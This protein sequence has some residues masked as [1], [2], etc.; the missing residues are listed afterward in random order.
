MLVAILC[1]GFTSAWADSYTITF[2]NNVN[3]ATGLSSSTNAST[4]ISSG[5][6]SYVTSKPFTIGSG[7]VY[8][9]DT[10]TCIRIG[11]SGNS[12]R[13][14]IGL[15]DTGKVKAT[16]IVVNC[17]YMSGSKN[18]DAKLNVNSIGEQTTPASADNKT[19][20]FASATD[21]ENIVLEGTAAIYIYSIT[22]N[23]STGGGSTGEETTTTI[24][25][26]GITN[27]NKFVSTV[28]G[29][30]SASV[31]YGEPAA[32]VS[33]ASVTW[34]GDNDAVATINS[35]TGVVTLVGA[36]TVTFTAEY[37][38]VTDTYLSS[39]D[40]YEMT[41]TNEDPSLETIWSED[42]SDYAANAVPSDGSFNYACTNGGGT[43]KIYT[44]ANA[45][46]TSPE[47]LVGKTNGT[48]SATVT[49]LHPTYSYS[50]D[51]T[52]RFKSNA[53]GINVNTT[54]DGITV[55]DEENEGEGVT[56]NTKETH[57]VTF[58]G[59]T[60]ETEN[61][62][63]VFTATTG[64][65]VRLD[66][67]VLKG[68]KA[69]LPITSIAF[70]E[71]K[72]A[73]VVVGY[74]VTLTPT[75]LP[76]NHTE[77]VDWESDATGVA[78]VNSD[79][80]VTGVAAGTAHITAKA[81][82][83]PST[84]YDVCTVTVTAPVSV[85]GVSLNKA[86]TTLLLGGTETLTATVAP[87]DATNKNVTWT[88]AD[89]SKVSVENGV[90]TALALTGGSPVS[91][92]VTTEDGSFSATCAVTVDPIHV[93]EISL[94][95]TSTTIE[96]TKT[97]TLTPTITPSNA[98]NKNVTWESDNTD[99]AT[100]SASGVVTG[101]AAGVANI[102]VTT[103]DGDLTATCEVTVV[104][105][106]GS[107][108][109]PYSVAEVINGA[110]G[111]DKYVVGYIVGCYESGSKTK[112][113]RNGKTNTNL[114]IA[115]DPEEDDVNHTVAVQLPS[116]TIRTNFNVQNNIHF[117]GSAKVLV[118][119]DITG[120]ITDAGLKNTNSI[121]KVA[122]AVKV[123]SAGFATW[124]SDSPLDFTD[125]DIDAYI[126]ITKGDGTGVTFTQINKVPANTGVLLYYEGGKTEE[127]PV[128]DGTGAESTAGNK[129]VK[130]AGE[131]VATYDGDN[132]NYILNQPSEK[133]IGFYRA[134]DQKVAKNRAYISIAKSE[135]ASVK[136]F[137]SIDFDSVTGINGITPATSLSKSAQIYN[138]AG[139][140]MSKLQKGVN[141]V[142]GKKVLVK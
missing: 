7:N 95:K 67:I 98:T 89:D 100:V 16:S 68:K 86:S 85:T 129:F 130:G 90:I 11:K 141:I 79:G 102:T 96:K 50:G 48:F 99:V 104:N 109:T 25:P 64:S 17:N 106:K 131:N 59:V 127:I 49:L 84:I 45:G 87:L 30:L 9:G 31:T 42:F 46:G 115:D 41:V 70:T 36:G 8:Y 135:S 55:K 97:E 118:C 113:G 10:K 122:E 63:I 66:D 54:T 126:A 75:V 83:N 20:N 5:S 14:T 23:Y 124:A 60:S 2:A 29:S 77:A 15:S 111:D 133:P 112:F 72:T 138:L 62:T 114:A 47:L 108:E 94:N 78:T 40:T 76:A 137:L 123:T 93:T 81:H 82:D 53:Y 117:I 1:A 120:Y 51:L 107:A 33:A 18:V 58:Q 52:L 6:T 69:T 28:A 139:Q 116:G 24:D 34:S 134:N 101:V 142:N 140:R 136:E 37:A 19:F 13:L 80:V 22:V 119:A 4:V 121:A 56:F 26:S 44:D 71:P 43:T 65:N 35:S 110:T 105:Q 3:S 74:T 88:S 91:I 128:F 21:I 132:Y 27:T 92:T 103:E 38:G 12:S 125:K 32:A 73:S 61:I 39:S 57:T